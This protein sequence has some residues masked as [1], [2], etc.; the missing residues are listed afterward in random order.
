LY[1]WLEVIDVGVDAH[2][3]VEITVGIGG[4]SK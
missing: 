2:V 1:I 3:M 4:N